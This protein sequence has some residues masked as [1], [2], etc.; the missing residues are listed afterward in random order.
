MAK[1]ITLVQAQEMQAG[2]ALLLDV[3]SPEEYQDGHP[4]GSISLPVERLAGNIIAVAGA[5]G[6]NRKILLYCT[7]GSRSRLAAQ[8]L[9]RLGY[10]NV[11]IIVL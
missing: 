8:V 9:Q 7:S 6:R 5:G 2:G 4:A 10:P 1:N 3:R 11:Y